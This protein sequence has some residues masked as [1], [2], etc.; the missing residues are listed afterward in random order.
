MCLWWW[1]RELAA[2]VASKVFFHLEEYEDALRLGL[3]AG[4]Y[5]DVSKKTEYVETMVAKAIDEYVKLKERQDQGG[6]DVPLIDPRLEAIVDKMFVRCV[7]GGWSSSGLA[8][9]VVGR[10]TC[11]CGTCRCFNDGAYN[12]AVGI[13]LESY[14]L[15][16]VSSM[17]RRRC[18]WGRRAAELMVWCG[19]LSRQLEEA[20]A[21]TPNKPALIAHIF[22]VSTPPCTYSTHSSSVGPCD[23]S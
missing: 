14:R 18:N 3:G 11:V 13:A 10:D 20:I 22:H 9:G 16:K 1:S 5:L 15:D 8:P 23:I 7:P 6:D 2:A 19:C 12:Q 17:A 21:L 4:P